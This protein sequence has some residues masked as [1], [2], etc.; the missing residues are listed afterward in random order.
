MG[1]GD[2]RSENFDRYIRFEKNLAN[3]RLFSRIVRVVV[4]TIRT[5][6]VT[7][8]V[9]SLRYLSAGTKYGEHNRDFIISGDERTKNYSR[10]S[11]SGRGNLERV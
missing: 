8:R 5:V 9:F 1:Y 7:S 4:I 6:S 3:F 10:E 2:R 11:K